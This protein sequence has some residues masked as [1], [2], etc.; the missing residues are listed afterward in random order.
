M[1]NRK[2]S[3]TMLQA[4]VSRQRGTPEHIELDSQTE[5]GCTDFD[6][7]GHVVRIQTPRETLIRIHETMHANHT[8]R[9]RYEKAYANVC[10]DVEQVTEDCRLHLNHWPWKRSETPEAIRRDVAQFTAKEIAQS[11]K[12]RENP[13]PGVNQAWP[14]FATRFRVAC[15]RE[16]MSQGGINRECYNAGIADDS[17]V[18]LAK[19]VARFLR[20]GR[21]QEAAE[22]IQAVF[23]PPEEIDL[24]P[25]P[26]RPGTI[27]VAKRPGGKSRGGSGRLGTMEI[28][29]LPHT[30]AI[31]SAIR[32]HRVARSGKRLYRPAVR[33]PILP[34]RLF[35]RKD[36]VKPGGTILIDASGSMGAWET[37][38]KWCE[39][40]PF[41]T[42][43]YYAGDD[44]ARK[45]WL[46]V[47]ARDG[48]R[49]PAIVETDGRDN[50]VDGLAIDWLVAQPGPRFMVTDREFCGSE[51]SEAQ[52]L[53]LRNLETAGVVRVLNYQ[54]GESDDESDD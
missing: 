16:G 49:A 46:M 23:F 14:Q 47:F 22:L 45:G 28:V 54:A 11:D 43:A 44:G 36:P 39:H 24:P 31:E 34:A 40:A 17:T 7:H 10:F 52:K 12:H 32:G 25:A 48:Y 30:E 20:N 21:E 33:K 51:D 50:T 37:I 26:P 4:A 3:N 2:V 13:K 27:T 42:V 19:T 15:I 5:G 9:K 29:E 6:P 1:A 38:A 8:D 53:R 41:A 18:N 35:L